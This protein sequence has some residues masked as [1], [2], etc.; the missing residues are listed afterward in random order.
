MQRIEYI[1]L[2]LVILFVCLLA[3]SMFGLIWVDIVDQ[4]KMKLRQ[5]R[6]WKINKKLNAKD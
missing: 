5:K 2:L 1:L 3:L 6:K 4:Y